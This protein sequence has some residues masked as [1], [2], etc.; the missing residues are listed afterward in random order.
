MKMHG[1]V[2]SGRVSCI[3]FFF[4]TSVSFETC[5]I[6]LT[7]LSLGGISFFPVDCAKT[8]CERL[9]FAIP[10]RDRGDELP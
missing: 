3:V 7:D 4:S 2:T 5:L 6:A 8:G 9:R 1:T 10:S